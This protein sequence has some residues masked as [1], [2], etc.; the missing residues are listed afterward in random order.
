MEPRKPILLA[1]DDSNDLELMMLAFQNIGMQQEI[2]VTRDGNE[3][4]DYLRCRGRFAGR[5]S[6][7]PALIL[8]DFRVPRVEGLRVLRQ[9]KQDDR[10]RSTPVVMFSSSPDPDDMLCSYYAG[11]NAYAVKP[12][13][14]EQFTRVLQ[15]V[16]NF[17]VAAGGAPA[18]SNGRMHILARLLE[19]AAHRSKG[20]DGQDG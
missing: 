15:C 4:L 2:V 10:L 9:V 16:T 17:W 3:T 7:N 20:N 12:L 14:F 13:D 6:G 19:R 18:R 1:E 8:L 5:A 11:V